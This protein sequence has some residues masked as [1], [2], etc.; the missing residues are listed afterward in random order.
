[1]IKKLILPL[2][3]VFILILIIYINNS[4]PS[5]AGPIGIL[6]VFSLIYGISI[7]LF[8]ILIRAYHYILNNASKY[9]SIFKPKNSFNL[10]SAYYYS[11][12][13]A[14][15]P[16]FVIGFSSVGVFGFYEIMLI[17]IFESL[18]IFYVRKK[19]LS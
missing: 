9:L 10:S 17:V 5:E 12:V 4:N 11:T 6:L 14:L 2:S 16:V 15:V 8:I 18:G 13:Y 1:M 3:I 19:V 7:A